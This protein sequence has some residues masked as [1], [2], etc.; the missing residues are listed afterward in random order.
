MATVEYLTKRAAGKEAE[1]QKLERKLD[2]INAARS[3]GWTKN[4]YLYHEEDAART[5]KEIALCKA[6]ISKYRDELQR[7]TEKA[8]SRD[9]EPI[10]KFL[11]G[12][13]AR[14]A[15]H[16]GKGLRAAFDDL[17]QINA[18]AKAAEVYGYGTDEYL[19]AREEYTAKRKAYNVRINGRY[20]KQVAERNGKR[21]T[22]DVKVEHGDLEYVAAMICETYE[23][24][25]TRLLKDLDAEA[26]RKYDFIIERTNAIVGKITDANGLTVGA[27]GDLNGYIYG[28]RGRARVQTIGA[29]GYNIQCF[30]FRT[31]IHAA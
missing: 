30:H 29:G 23:E 18:L 31:L 12:W 24:S 4:P 16:Y 17:E 27:K 25:M 11:D 19:A 28:T 15:E 10:K 14:C 5:E 6:A 1:L 22:F 21:Y 9:V 8:N 2:R 3:T 13:K 26:N 7:A 20:E